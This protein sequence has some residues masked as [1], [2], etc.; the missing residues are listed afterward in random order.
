MT[1]SVILL[2]LPATA[3]W[4]VGINA[5]V[6]YNIY[7]RSNHYMVNWTYGNGGGSTFGISGQ[8]DIPKTK[9][10]GIRADLSV[11]SKNHSKTVALNGTYDLK[12]Y[13]K[14]LLLPIMASASI[15]LWSKFNFFTNLGVYGGYWVKKRQKD[16]VPYGFNEYSFFIEGVDNTFV[17]ERDQRFDIGFVGGVGLEYEISHKWTTLLELRSYYST[18]SSVKEYMMGV[19]DFRYDTTIVLQLGLMYKL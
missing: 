3:Q 6:D 17:S 19:K 12:S 16:E 14:Y 8:Y 10:L 13:N 1:L 11:I 5:G 15:N 2:Q 9:W 7:T 18:V 4:R